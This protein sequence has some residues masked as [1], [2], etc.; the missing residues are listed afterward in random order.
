MRNNLLLPSVKAFFI[1]LALLMFSIYAEGQN[2]D[3]KQS[4]LKVLRSKLGQKKPAEA[5]QSKEAGEKKS[6]STENQA[7]KGDQKGDLDPDE[8]ATFDEDEDDPDKMGE[9]MMRKLGHDPASVKRMM[10]ENGDDADPNAIPEPDAKALASI[11]ATP[12]SESELITYLRIFDNGAEKVLSHDAQKDVAPHLNK[13]QQTKEAAYMLWMTGKQEASA[14]LMMKASL[15]D[16]QDELLLSNLAAVLTMAGYA[17]KSIPILEYLKTKDPQSS[18]VNNNLGQAWLSLGRV[19]K[20][21]PLLEQAVSKYGQHP[22]ANRSLARIAKKEGNAVKAKTYLE[23]ALK[24]GFSQE[25]YYELK[26]M[27][28]DR[29]VD[30]MNILRMDHKRN[31]KNI[32]ATKRFT[33]PVVPG[34]MEVAIKREQEIENYFHG[35][36]LTSEDIFRKIPASDDKLFL[37]YK[38]VTEQMAANSKSMTSL[39]DVQKQYNLSSRIFTPY[40]IQAQEMLTAELDDSYAS[41]FNKRMSK[42]KQSREDQMRSLNESLAA[43]HAKLTDMETRLS[44]MET[45]EGESPA[46]QALENQI[47]ALRKQLSEIMV[48]KSATINN[49]FV[50][51]MESLA[52]QRLQEQTYWYTLYHLPQDPTD[53]AYRLYADYLKTLSGLKVY[54]PYPL[55]P[56]YVGK[57]CEVKPT[58]PVTGRG[59][60]AVWEDTHCVIH[61]DLDFH[62]VKSKFT[63]KEVTIGAKVY[64]FEVGGGQKYDPSTLETVEHSIYFGMKVGKR[65]ADVGETLAAQASAGIVTTLKVDGNWNFKDFIIKGTAGAEL[66][67]KVPKS[68]DPNDSQLDIR[69]AASIGASQSF[70]LSIVSGFRNAGSKVSTVGN[71]FNRL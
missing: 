56:Q 31:Y 52:F 20:A 53:L 8:E 47:C 44:K 18:I 45:G 7:K 48:E 37:S 9:K 15:A 67:L 70:E 54:Y 5:N 50:Q 4:P 10:N 29:S 42:L 64:G 69:Q 19:D 41:S 28:T 30:L 27:N 6:S 60:M 61:W 3:E 12:R 39:E 65:G 43:D 63:C 57:G 51:E 11:K 26:D 62:L 58:T 46:V 59:K 71:I 14:Y 2:K 55:P 40:K 34:S 24:G 49:A 21:K 1:V 23:N 13:G 33:M 36:N 38:Q 25:A 17:D 16:P 32:A 22:E 68:T 35:I 66:G